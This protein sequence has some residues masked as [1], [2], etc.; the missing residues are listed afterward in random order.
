MQGQ[1]LSVDAAGG[2]R[3]EDA[4][5]VVADVETDNGVIHVIEH[6]VNTFTECPTGRAPARLISLEAWADSSAL[7]FVS[8]ALQQKSCTPLI[9]LFTAILSPAV[10]PDRYRYT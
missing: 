1:G 9:V 2:V 3:V 8:R 4:N 7:F 5:V 6:V 10:I